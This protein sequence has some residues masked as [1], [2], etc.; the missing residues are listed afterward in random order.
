MPPSSD[1]SATYALLDGQTAMA[2][3]H[4]L[5]SITI[6]P[7]PEEP[8]QTK[9]NVPDR[10]GWKVSG[11]AAIHG[12][13]MVTRAVVGDRAAFARQ[14]E[15]AGFDM[16][17]VA[18]TRGG[19]GRLEQTADVAAGRVRDSGRRGLFAERR[20]LTTDDGSARSSGRLG[21]ADGVDLM[22]NTAGFGQRGRS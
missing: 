1:R 5:R 4:A 8:A 22:V 18:G 21:G 12:V 7:D 16:R 9:K 2:G 10:I 11:Y 6:P 3:S 13:A 15:A 17:V 14:M 20:N 19:G